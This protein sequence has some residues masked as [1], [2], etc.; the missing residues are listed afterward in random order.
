MTLKYKH[1]ATSLYSHASFKYKSHYTG[2]GYES[3]THITSGEITVIN[4]NS[5]YNQITGRSYISNVKNYCLNRFINRNITKDS[6]KFEISTGFYGDEPGAKLNSS[7]E[8]EVNVFIDTLNGN[9]SDDELIEMI[10]ID[11]YGFILDELKNKTW[12]FKNLPIKNI[13]PSGGM[14]HTSKDIIEKYTENEWQLSCVCQ[15]VGDKYRLID[16]YHRYSAAF[17]LNKKKI[18][19][20]YCE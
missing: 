6:Y 9:I 11:E 10:F 7:V 12:I 8:T 5:I 19:T 15:K 14:R 16:G 20:I 1:I 3:R 18:I 4:Y 13:I 2:E 17:K